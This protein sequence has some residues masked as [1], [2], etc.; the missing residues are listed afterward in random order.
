MGLGFQT[1]TL[2][3]ALIPSCTHLEGDITSQFA[4]QNKA[5]LWKLPHLPLSLFLQTISDCL[6]SLSSLSVQEEQSPY[7]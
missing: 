7:L 1:F 6:S 2:F 4:L 5:A 3:S